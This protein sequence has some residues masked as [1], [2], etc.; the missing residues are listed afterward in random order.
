[1]AFDM[2][3][4]MEME[5]MDF[6]DKNIFR[7]KLTEPATEALFRFAKIHQYDA[8]DDFKEAW[9]KWRE[10]QIELVE[11][12][13]R[14]LR[15]LGYC[16]DVDEKMFKSARYY[17]RK[18]STETKEPSQ[19]RAYV[20]CPK[21]LLNAMDTHIQDG[22]SNVFKP[23]DGFDDFCGKNADLVNAEVA[24]LLES[25]FTDTN[26]IKHKIKKT[27]KNRYFRLTNRQ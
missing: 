19:R 24:V 13:T 12:E 15:N 14:R 8:L 1:M 17:F 25:G 26:A 9:N 11:M 5:M 16:G 2:G 22:I 7:Y 23:S 27:Y 20:S 3:L 6:N 10:N 21:N 4:E 18:K